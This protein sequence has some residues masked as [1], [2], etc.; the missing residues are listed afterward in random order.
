M[1]YFKNDLK[2]FHLIKSIN[3]SII[4]AAF[5]V[6]VQVLTSIIIYTIIV[7]ETGAGTL[8]SWILLQMIIGYGGLV[9]LGMAQVI[10]KEVA[11]IMNVENTSNNTHSLGESLSYSLFIAFILS[12][13]LLLFSDII[14]RIIQIGT[15][16][17]VN[18]HCLWIMLIGV[19]IRLFSSIYGSILTGLHRNYLLYICQSLQLIVF[20]SFFLIFYVKSNIINCLSIAFTVGYTVEFISV[21]SILCHIDSSFVKIIPT[22]RINKLV[23]FKKKVLPYLMIDVSLLGREPLLKFALFASSGPA[24]VGLFELASKIPTAIRQVFVLGLNALMPAFVDLSRL[25]LRNSIIHLGQQFLNYII[26]GAIGVLFLYGINSYNIF[27]IWFGSVSNELISMTRLLTFWWIVTSLNIPAWYIG[28]GL[29]NGWSNSLIA[30]THLIYTFIL[31]ITSFFIK[32]N[33]LTI[34]CI[35]IFGGLCMQIL[36]YSLIENRTNFIYLLYFSKSMKMVYL[37]FFCFCLLTFV[38]TILFIKPLFS[39]TFTTILSAVLFY[40]LFLFRK[41]LF[42]LKA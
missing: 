41:P 35:W 25:K 23:K 42:N 18:T 8:G 21:F 32:M 39:N 14:L 15:E 33:N 40:L 2:I 17:K 36:L 6:S 31:V 29:D 38:M 24:S 3:Y 1:I 9:H 19:V 5:K 34:I 26:W 10:V 7:R 11:S 4:L 37:T 28:I 12:I 13:L 27:E 16:Q 22:L 20:T 30:S